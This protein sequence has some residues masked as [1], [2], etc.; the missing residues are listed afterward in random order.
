MLRDI[1]EGRFKPLRCDACN[2]NLVYI[3]MAGVTCPRCGKLYD[4]RYDILLWSPLTGDVYPV[5]VEKMAD[6]EFNWKYKDFEI[7]TTHTCGKVQKPYLELIKWSE[8]EG[9]RY[10]WTLAYWYRDKDDDWELRFVCNRP[11]EE[12][13][14]VD[15]SPIWRQLFLAQQMLEDAERIDARC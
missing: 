3:Y 10:C 8:S 15:V 12:I 7:R 13:S 5:E 11:L 9:K 4:K 2:E 1:S 6:F 14:D